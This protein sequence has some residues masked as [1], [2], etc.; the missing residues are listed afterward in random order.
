MFDHHD[1]HAISQLF[2][3][4]GFDDSFVDDQDDLVR[5]LIMEIADH[6]IVLFAVIKQ[7]I[8]TN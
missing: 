8:Y 3:I 4:D 6:D 1:F 7:L 5:S 2:D